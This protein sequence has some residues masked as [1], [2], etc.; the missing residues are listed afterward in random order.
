MTKY[1]FLLSMMLISNFCN[2]QTWDEW[3]RQ[4]K[5]QIKY[6]EQQIIAL[7]AYS[8][9]AQKGYAIVRDGLSAIHDIKNGDFN[10]HKDYFNS[11][12]SVNA[13]V[14]NGKKVTAVI[15]LQLCILQQ[16]SAI[17]TILKAGHI[18]NSE[19]HYI[20]SVMND[21]LA[22]CAADI[23]NLTNLSTD[24]IISMKDDERLKR[25]ESIYADMMGRYNFSC[26]FKE[27]IQRLSLSRAKE[28]SDIQT[29]QSL[30]NIK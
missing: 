30:Y 8:N 18:L 29:L 2:A 22:T 15:D 12:K 10:L 17:N 13:A 1:T 9:S 16:N 23:S 19:S 21:V 7:Q 5:T 28:S 20:R 11:L 25:I 27:Q 24:G 26:H 3:F 6:L 14:G 4:K